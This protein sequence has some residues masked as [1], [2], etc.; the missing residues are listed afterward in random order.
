MSSF[1]EDICADFSL[2]H[3]RVSKSGSMLVI[4]DLLSPALLIQS[5]NKHIEHSTC[6]LYLILCIRLNT[7]NERIKYLNSKL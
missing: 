1:L 4:Q 6:P 7:W 5:I 3:F 2:K